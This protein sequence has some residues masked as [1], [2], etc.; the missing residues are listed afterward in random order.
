[1]S[2]RGPPHQGQVSAS[3]A[4]ADLGV[5]LRAREQ[6][7]PPEAT[8]GLRVAAVDTSLGT[9]QTHAARALEALL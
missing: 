7:E 3:M 1:M 6:H 8:E 9:P 4:D 5:H 2:L